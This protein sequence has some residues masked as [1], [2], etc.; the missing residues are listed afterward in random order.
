MAHWYTNVIL[1]FNST[2]PCD[3]LEGR[4]SP[5]HPLWLLQE[6]ELSTGVWPVSIQLDPVSIY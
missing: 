1:P 5:L 2:D 3:N 4:Q 6:G